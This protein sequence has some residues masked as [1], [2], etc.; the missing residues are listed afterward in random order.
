MDALEDDE[1][2]QDKGERERGRRGRMSGKK[3]RV[4]GGERDRERERRDLLLGSGRR[5]RKR[6]SRG[7]RGARGKENVVLCSS[8]CRSSSPGSFLRRGQRPTKPRS[9]LHS[10][11]DCV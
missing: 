4:G 8:R 6:G 9:R 2:R 3:T 1:R 5:G 7:S 10:R 11:S